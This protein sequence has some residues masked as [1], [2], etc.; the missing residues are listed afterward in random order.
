MPRWQRVYLAACA[1]VIGFALAYAGAD[2]GKLPHLYHD[3]LGHRFVV[4]AG[5]PGLAS[6]YPGLILWGLAGGLVAALVT[7]L[8]AGRRRA[9]VSER[10]LGLAAAWAGTAV[11]LAVGYFV[12]NNA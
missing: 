6:G 1:G 12:W 4:G 7:W 9:P 8:V 5:L 10:S 3:Q 2:Y 11:L